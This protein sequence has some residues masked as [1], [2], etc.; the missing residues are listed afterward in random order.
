MIPLSLYGVMLRMQQPHCIA[1][2]VFYPCSRPH[3]QMQKREAKIYISIVGAFVYISR[4]PVIAFMDTEV[5]MG[6]GVQTRNCNLCKG[7]YTTAPIKFLG[8]IERIETS[9]S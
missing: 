4:Y 5:R 1:S 6:C 7:R 2:S 3:R 8:N 9:V